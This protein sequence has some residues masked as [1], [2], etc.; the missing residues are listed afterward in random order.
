MQKE[1]WLKWPDA[2]GILAEA[3]PYMRGETRP[4]R[5]L[6]LYVQLI[7]STKLT[8]SQKQALF[9]EEG[10]SLVEAEPRERRVSLFGNFRFGR[11]GR[12]TISVHYLVQVNGFLFYVTFWNP[13]LSRK[14]IDNNE[15]KFLRR[16]WGAKWLNPQASSSVLYPSSLDWATMVK[17][18]PLW[19]RGAIRAAE[20]VRPA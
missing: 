4:P 1:K 18:H 11:S 19:L 13:T 10:L 7:V 20:W 2:L 8:P 6:R 16:Y 5:N 14:Q 12:S 15:A 3:T 17:K 9:D